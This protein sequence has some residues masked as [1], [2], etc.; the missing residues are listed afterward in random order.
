MSLNWDLCIICQCSTHEALR[1]PMKSHSF[2]S[3]VYSNFLTNVT[4][5]KDLNSLPVEL[6]FNTDTTTTDDL[7]KNNAK[8]HQSCHLKFSSSKL[9][10]AQKRKSPPSDGYEN[11][12]L[13]SNKRHKVVESDENRCLFCGEGNKLGVLHGFSTIE[14]DSNLCRIFTDLQDL[15]LL[16]KISGGDLIAIEGKYHMKCL[17]NLRNKH[18]SHQRKT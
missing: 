8:W 6:K 10:K 9:K 7:I 18:R 1:C 3:N 14:A 4:H 17:T 15:K 12:H 2:D 16:A 5:F 11:P 13:K